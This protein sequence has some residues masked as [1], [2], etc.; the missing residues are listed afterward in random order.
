MEPIYTFNGQD[1]TMVICL[2]IS[3]LVICQ[4]PNL[5]ERDENPQLQLQV[6]TDEWRL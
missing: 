1:I 3:N 4:A 6:Q 2:L 5:K